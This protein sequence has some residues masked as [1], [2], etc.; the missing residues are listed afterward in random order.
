MEEES[1]EAKTE[2]KKED[3][4]EES[5]EAKTDDKPKEKIETEDKK[6]DKTEEPLTEI[7]SEK[8][9]TESDNPWGI[10]SED[11]TKTESTSSAPITSSDYHSNPI[12]STEDHIT[13]TKDNLWKYSTFILVG[14]LVVAFFMN[15]GGDNTTGNVIDNAGEGSDTIPEQQQ[16]P[17]VERVQVS[18]DD[19]AVR[20]DP[21][22]PVTIIEFSDYECP[23]CGRFYTQTLDQ[24][25]T[26]YIDTGKV[27]MV[28]RDFPL[29]FHP[30]AQKAAEAAECAG[31]QDKYFEMHDMLFD[32]QQSLNIDSY[33]KYAGE[34]GLDQEEFDEC[35][36]SDAM[37]DEVRKDFQ[38][39][40]AAG[41][42]GTPGFFINGKILTGAQPFS[43]FEAAIEAELAAI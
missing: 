19:D 36:D 1:D 17:V 16:P 30:N 32:D 35:L 26:N 25:K 7:K 39:G 8:T 15:F 34:L 4:E 14:I 37:A 18:V 28:Y 5:D 12:S 38:D 29:S 42:T 2:D 22:A 13:I 9:K 20:G 43:A 27:K 24:I 6:E 23:F 10:K 41:V 11:S 31:E 3:K 21:D 40:Q 33:K